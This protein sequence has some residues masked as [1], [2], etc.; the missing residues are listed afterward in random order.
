MRH[1]KVLS[2]LNQAIEDFG[3]ALGEAEDFIHREEPNFCDLI[4]A[5]AFGK[6]S[7]TEARH[8]VHQAFA[9]ARKDVGQWRRL[10]AD[11]A[12]E[13]GFPYLHDSLK[14]GRVIAL[15]PDPA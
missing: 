2:G 5:V 3:Y 9:Q 1:I 10:R 8:I 14:V 7:S 11:A 6:M 4:D 15:L 12:E 13:G